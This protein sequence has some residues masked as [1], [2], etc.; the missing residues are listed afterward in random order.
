MSHKNFQDTVLKQTPLPQWEVAGATVTT[1]PQHMNA[2][3]S[4]TN[5]GGCRETLFK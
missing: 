4:K 2:I 1:E 3:K 5:I